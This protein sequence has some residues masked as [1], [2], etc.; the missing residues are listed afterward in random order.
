MPREKFDQLEKQ[1]DL[2]LAGIING[3]DDKTL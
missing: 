3:D 2:M 1:V